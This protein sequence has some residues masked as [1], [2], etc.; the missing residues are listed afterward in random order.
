MGMAQVYT[1]KGIII[2]MINIANLTLSDQL[3]NAVEKYKVF[4]PNSCNAS[5]VGTYVSLK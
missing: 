4:M 1:G 5:R 2:L 3:L